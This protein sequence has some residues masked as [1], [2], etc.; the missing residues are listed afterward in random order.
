MSAAKKG[1]GRGFDSLIPTDLFDESFDP[2][3]QEDV[4]VSKLTQ[5][6]ISKIKPNPDQ[7]RRTFDEEAINELAES[8]REHGVLQPIIVAPR[9]DGYII[10]AGERRYRASKKAGIDKIP[11]IIRTLTDQN[12]LEVSLIENIQRRD[13]NTIETAT[14]YAKLRDQFNMTNEQIAKR[15]NK[16][17]SAVVNTMRLLKLPKEV[18]MTIA[19]GR[20]S[21]GQARPLIGQSDDLVV[22]LVPRIINEEWSARKVE[23]YVVNLKKAGKQEASASK[24]KPDPHEADTQFLRK[25]F[26]TNISIQTN[27]KGAGKIVIPFKSSKDFERIKKML[28]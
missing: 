6:A 5:M 7:P 22:Q 23:Q 4:Q 15:V 25:R 3:A 9:G 21:E 18:V 1:L 2:T 24:T 13:L 19:E 28:G 14:A 26:D 17:V 16:S 10:V 8:V 11:V 12:Q 27:T 20:L